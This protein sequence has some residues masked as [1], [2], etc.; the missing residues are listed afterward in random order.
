M[1]EKRQR[2]YLDE[3]PWQKESD[4]NTMRLWEALRIPV[5]K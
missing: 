5:E 4:E 3:T 2:N 1:G